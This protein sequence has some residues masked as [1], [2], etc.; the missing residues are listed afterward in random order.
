MG[1]MRSVVSGGGD[2]GRD[3]MVENSRSERERECEFN[4]QFLQ[5]RTPFETRLKKLYRF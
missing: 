5:R 3:L 4:S 1:E 2:L